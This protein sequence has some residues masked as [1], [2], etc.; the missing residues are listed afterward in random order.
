MHVKGQMNVELTLLGGRIFAFPLP[1][2]EAIVSATLSQCH[3]IHISQSSS[4]QAV[5]G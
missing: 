5:V 2:S 3:F 1:A 4:V